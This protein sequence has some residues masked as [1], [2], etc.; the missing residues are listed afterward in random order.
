MSD[1]NGIYKGG[2]NSP[3]PIAIQGVKK[4]PLQ[5]SSVGYN[6]NILLLN[7]IQTTGLLMLIAVKVAVCICQ[8]KIDPNLN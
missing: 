1:K 7:E 2:G 3:P 6:D 8:L 5:I 4:I